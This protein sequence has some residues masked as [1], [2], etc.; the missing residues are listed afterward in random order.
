MS[1]SSQEVRENLTAFARNDSDRT[2]RASELSE[3]ALAV[4]EK[5]FL[6]RD[7]HGQLIENP[8]GLF[9]RVAR[10]IAAIEDIAGGFRREE[11]EEI[12]FE[13]M[14]SL[15]FLPNSPT[16]MNAGTPRGQ[17]AGCFVLPVEDSM[18]SIYGTL[19]DVALIQKSGGGTGFSFSHLRPRGDYIGST[20]GVSSGP[21]SFMRL[22]DYSTQINRL[23][24]TRAGANMGILRC[25]HPDIHEFVNAKKDP[26]SLSSFNISVMA[27]DEF[28]RAVVAGKEIPLRFPSSNGEGP[29]A[30]RGKINAAGLFEEI[31]MNAWQT[32]DPGLLFY[33]RINAANPTPQ[34]GPI[35][36]TN[37][38]GEQPLLAYES[39]NLG[40]INV[41]KFVTAG[42]INYEELRATVHHAVHFL[43]NVLDANSYSVEAVREVTMGNRKV[44]LGIMGF[45]DLLV[46]LRI[47]YASAAAIALAEEM[48][49]FI[50]NQAKVAS[51]KLAQTRGP[52]PNFHN[53]RLRAENQTPVRNACVTSIA[54]TGTISLLANCSSGIEPF[55][56]LSYRRE[57]IG[58]TKMIDVN[59]AVLR[60]LRS[61]IS[62][63]EPVLKQ[64]RSSGRLNGALIPRELRDLF[65]T[66]HEIAPEWHVKMQAAF[67][68]YTDTSVS[69]TINLPNSSRP[70]AVAD[71]YQLAF[72]TACKGVTVFRDGC[73]G[74]QV[75]RA[76]ADAEHCPECGDPLVIQGGCRNCPFCGYSIC[77]V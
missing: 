48:M 77:T 76:G 74:L 47:P 43:D 25:D 34:L 49:G 30:I 32:G 69:K 62:E 38:C 56:A 20:R 70:E 40:S 4:L 14:T 18:E 72:Q 28:M 15:K 59:P 50:Q 11:S 66:A 10:A 57:V 67:Q 73:K 29:E 7:E 24:G 36:A 3:H 60:M 64:V 31:V 63:V 9:H 27:T 71:A 23:G 21:V 52:F 46:E 61:E 41:S 33:D 13:L 45:A 55:F 19:R 6:L 65:A 53:S 12:F 58:A 37:P 5:R 39:C 35:E 26:E 2:R 54:P 42:T 22:Y 17:L 16:L 51:S 8:A 1:S 44:G 75:L 68:K